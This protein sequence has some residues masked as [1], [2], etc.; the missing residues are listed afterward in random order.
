MLLNFPPL[1]RD[2]LQ[3]VIFPKG[4]NHLPLVFFL[5]MFI[6]CIHSQND[7]TGISEVLENKIFVTG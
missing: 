1:L 6:L 4:I 2:N 3:V 5:R 7:E